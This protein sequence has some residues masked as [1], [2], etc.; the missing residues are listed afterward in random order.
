MGL[1]NDFWLWKASC[2]YTTGWQIKAVFRTRLFELVS[3][4]PWGLLGILWNIDARMR[5]HGNYI[6]SVAIFSLLFSVQ[7]AP[8]RVLFERKHPQLKHAVS[9][10]LKE[11]KWV[12]RYEFLGGSDYEHRLNE[13]KSGRLGFTSPYLSLLICKM[14][15][16]IVPVSL[17]CWEN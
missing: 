12:S 8:C 15:I 16:I 10:F 7:Q 11:V 4:E 13:F 2:Q 1:E 17:S 6:L 14:W 3:L 9:M 5:E